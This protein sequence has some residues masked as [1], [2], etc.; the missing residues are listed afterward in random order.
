[1]INNS[2]SMG[3]KANLTMEKPRDF[4]FKEIL[5][6]RGWKGGIELRGQRQ[7]EV[8]EVTLQ[9]ISNSIMNAKSNQ[10]EIVGDSIL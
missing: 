10:N 6:A 7:E 3:V 1:M 4:F 5:E 2:Q 9:I 8:E